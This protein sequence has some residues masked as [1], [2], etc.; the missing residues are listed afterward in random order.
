LRKSKDKARMENA[1]KLTFKDTF[2]RIEALHCP[3]LK[4]LNA[5]IRSA[6]EVHNNAG[7]TGRNYSRRS[8]FEDIEREVLAP[9]SPVR[10]QVKK[11][12]PATVARD[13]Y[14]RLREDIRYYNVPHTYTGKKPGITCS[15]GDAG[16]IVGYG[17]IAAHTRSRTAFRHTASP[18]HPS[19]RHRAVPEYSPGNFL[20]QA[21]EIH[22]D[23][24]HYIRK[25]P[26]SKRCVDRANK[27][28]SGIRSLVRRAGAGR[29]EAAC[30]PAPNY[31]KYC[32]LEVQDMLK[33]KS[34]LIGLPE[35]T[36][37]IYL[38]T[39][40]YYEGKIVTGKKANK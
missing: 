21:A 24:A 13:G 15:S 22:E 20:K 36:P 4:S 14:V 32:F 7:L 5:A 38:S 39:K 12:V 27:N 8:Y 25:V 19:P 30:R 9:L 29:L 11:H 34:E 3:N 18:E 35:E 28:C 40:T 33:T 16:I 1:I 6:P 37:G 10:C 17:I 23:A 31:G 2:I 26:E